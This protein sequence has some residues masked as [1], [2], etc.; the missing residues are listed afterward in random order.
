LCCYFEEKKYNYE[1]REGR[2]EGIKLTIT[3]FCT[4]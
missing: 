4:F 3:T 2:K 1:R